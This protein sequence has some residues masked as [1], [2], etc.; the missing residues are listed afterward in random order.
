MSVIAREV[1]LVSRPVGLPG[2]EN[3]ALVERRLDEPRAG[4]VLVRNR[5]MSVDPYMRGRMREGK[6][7]IPPFRLGEPLEGAA[8]GVVEASAA[9]GFAPG[10][11]VAHFA[12]WRDRALVDASGA[13]RVDQGVA[14]L[15]AYLGALGGPGLAAYVGLLRVARPRRGETVFVSAAA[16]AVGSIACQIAALHGCRVVASAGSDAK[17]AWLRD[18]LGVDAAINYRTAGDFRA[19]LAAA[20]PDGIDVYFDN[21]GGVQLDAALAV[22]NDFARFALCGMIEQ[23][24]E[25]T[26]AP[27]LPHLYL[28]VTRRIALQG[29][30]TPDHQEDMPA[31]TADMARWIRE[32]RIRWRETVVAG[33][34][35]APEAFVGLFRGENI[36]KMLVE[37][38]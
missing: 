29:F 33:L 2:P 32:G 28:A 16:G 30:I 6:S 3:F 36:G 5:W 1:H 23:Y 12:G 25:E 34:E 27:V 14:P 9:P 21:V 7:Y 19:A 4:Q 17:I 37:L 15:P 31:F 20:C 18:E 22:A 13:T 35:R 38:R 10:D 24:N 11:T 8:V 26:P